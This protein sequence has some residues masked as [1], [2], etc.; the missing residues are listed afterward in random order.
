MLLPDGVYSMS[1]DEF[2]SGLEHKMYN[3]KESAQS[4]L[5]N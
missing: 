4:R 1:M 3:M 2:V 5:F